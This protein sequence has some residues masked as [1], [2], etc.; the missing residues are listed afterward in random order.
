MSE[1]INRLLLIMARLRDPERGCEWDTAQ[2]FETIAP[3]TIEEAYE[4]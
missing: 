3:Y 4:V 2:T 1:Q